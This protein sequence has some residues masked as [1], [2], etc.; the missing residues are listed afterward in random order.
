MREH[1]ERMSAQAVKDGKPEPSIDPAGP[2]APQEKRKYTKRKKAD[3]QPDSPT[4]VL[5]TTEI[6]EIGQSS[7]S[8]TSKPPK[9]KRTPRPPR[10]PSPE[11][12]PSTLTEEQLTKP[13]ISYVIILH[14]V[15]S[16]C[17]AGKMSLPSIYRAIE[18]KYLWFKFK[19]TTLG[20]QSSVRHNLNQHPVF[21]KLERDGKG[22]M[23]GLDPTI[24]IEKEKKARRPSPPTVQHQH[25]LYH[26]PPGYRPP[27]PTYPG[28]PP[29]NGQMPPPPA[30][31]HYAMYS[32]PPGHGYPTGAPPMRMGMPPLVAQQN[33]SDYQ[34]PYTPAPQVQN[35][36]TAQTQ[37][38]NQAQTGHIPQGPQSTGSMQTSNQ[39]EISSQGIFQQANQPSD[40]QVTPSRAAAD[41]VPT[42]A[43]HLHQPTSSAPVITKNMQETIDKFKATLITSLVGKKDAEEVVTRSINRALGYP[44][45]AGQPEEIPED[46]RAII[47]V[48]TKM[49]DQ[50]REKD[51]Q[52]ASTQKENNMPG[53]A[54][55]SVAKEISP[56]QPQPRPEANAQ[57][58]AVTEQALSNGALAATTPAQV[59]PSTQVTPA[60]STIKPEDHAKISSWF[61]NLKS[62]STSGAQ[63]GTNGTAGQA[64]ATTEQI[65]ETLTKGIEAAEAV[66]GPIESIRNL[67]RDRDS[68][69][70]GD[71]GK[72]GVDQE[73]PALKRVAV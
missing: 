14:D 15:I 10:S 18:R 64:R 25:A 32:I 55:P 9:E 59:A 73:Q 31:N 16:E 24:P 54:S 57:V 8:K 13:T 33:S 35:A 70:D 56:P 42:P 37:P 5:E 66:V 22:W 41:S 11:I 7:E 28:M 43:S 12:D 62:A 29:Q 71:G 19:A 53:Q 69:D 49:L 23:W 63:N 26:G 58:S 72:M 39:T 3:D 38:P 40:N 47:T 50:L 46:E 67:K 27:Y 61:A 36:Q 6:A 45:P 68:D 52:N 30:G 48:L 17:P 20:W 4:A 34:S 60:P 51:R 65:Q 1:K 2:T 21:K 44:I